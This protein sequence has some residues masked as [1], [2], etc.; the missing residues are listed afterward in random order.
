MIIRFNKKESIKFSRLQS[1]YSSKI[2]PQNFIHE[3]NT[4]IV[5]DDGNILSESEAI[6]NII[7]D[8]DFPAKIL[9]IF[10]LLPNFL[11]NYCYRFISRNR[12][13]FFQSQVCTYNKNISKRFIE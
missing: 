8:L 11:L 4:V 13:K 3:M 7:K 9:L 6:F 10:N 2:L 5:L 12:K 1:D